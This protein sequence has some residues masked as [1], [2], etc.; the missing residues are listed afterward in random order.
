MITEKKFCKG[1]GRKLEDNPLSSI[2]GGKQYYEF[3][4]GFYCI[5]CA[6]L[7]LKKRRIK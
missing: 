2:I 7:K 3:Q 1:C 5:E 4:D 6:R